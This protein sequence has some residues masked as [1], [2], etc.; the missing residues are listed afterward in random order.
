MRVNIINC[1]FVL[2]SEKNNNIRKN[3]IKK[4]KTLVTKNKELLSIKYS[5]KDMKEDIRTSLNNI[6]GLKKVHLEQVYT[7]ASNDHVDIIYLGVCN[8]DDVKDIDKNY[9]LVDFSIKT[10]ESV[11]LDN[12]VYKYKT[13]DIEKD[14]SVEY[15]HEIYAED[16][17]KETLLYLLTSYKRIRTNLDISDIMFKFL[18]DTFTLED[19]RG[20]YELV[21]DTSVDKSNFRKKIVKYCEK[22]DLKEENNNGYRPSQKYRFKALKGDIWL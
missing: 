20:V 13:I 18:P 8:I 10:N 5:G 16:K 14:N 17:I 3:D 19:V 4:I 12:E 1:L 7:F 21:K 9:E 11:S 22:V 15:I 6:L 2:D